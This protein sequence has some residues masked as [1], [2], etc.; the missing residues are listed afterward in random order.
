VQAQLEQLPEH[1]A[2]P[3][4]AAQPCGISLEDSPELAALESHRI[5]GLL[6]APRDEP[7]WR[8]L[9]NRSLTLLEQ[10]RD[11]RVLA[12]LMAATLR[13]GSL[14]EALDIFTLLHTWLTRY[15][16]HVHPVLEEDA[17][18][19]RNALNCFCDRTID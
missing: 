10:S 8:E 13:S 16:D 7:D 14:I 17:I 11:V 19:R 5:F 4:S 3:I 2:E 12:H 15:F 9:R 6:V 1:L 18:A